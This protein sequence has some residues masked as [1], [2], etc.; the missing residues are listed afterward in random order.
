MS[1]Y[2]L[3]DSVELTESISLHKGGT[4]PIGTTGAIAEFFNQGEAYEVE[5]FGGWVK[6]DTQ[7]NFIPSNR[8]DPDSFVETIGLATLYPHQFKVVIPASETVS[9]RARLAA[10]LEELSEER[11]AAVEDFADFL[12]HQQRQSI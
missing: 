6:Y 5:L 12:R 1:Q 11:L 9:V 8:A 7:G 2:N 4:A 3:F 10:I